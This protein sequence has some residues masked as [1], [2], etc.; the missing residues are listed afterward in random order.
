MAQPLNVKDDTTA[1]HPRAFEPVTRVVTA[2]LSTLGKRPVKHPGTDR[3]PTR[4][5]TAGPGKAAPL[6]A[7]TI[8]SAVALSACAGG[9]VRTPASNSA[10]GNSTFVYATNNNVVTD[11]DPG[12][13]Y[14]NE[15]IA[16][17]NIYESLTFYDPA[18]KKVSPRLATAWTSS[19]DGKTWTF[20]LPGNAKFHS[21]RAL[22]ATAAKESIERTIKL[23]G[24][25][26]YIWASVSTITAA[27]PTSL[28]FNLK[29]PAPLDLIASSDYGAY[30]YDV[31]AAG[32]TDLKSWLGKGHD[33]G[34]GPYTVD[35]WQQGQATELR[36]KAVPDYWASWKG[37]HYQNIEFRVSPQVT[38]SWQLLQRGEVSF[39]NKVN[40]QIFE[41]AQTTSGVHASSTSSFQNDLAMFN[42]A[43]GPMADIRVRKAVQAAIDT[44][45]LLAALKGDGVAASQ[46]I[47]AGL[48]GYTPDLQLR[49]NLETA[50][51]LLSEAG[52]G[53]GGK[54]L[55]LNLT[56]AQGDSD[57]QLF[58]TLLTSA[59]NQLGVKLNA[60]PMQWNAQSAQARST[61]LDS[62]QD[63]LVFRWYPDYADPYTW[64]L[65]LF[66]SSQQPHF[67]VT[68]LDD[69]SVDATIDSI[70]QL[71]ATSRDQAQS[72]YA[73]LQATLVQDKAVVAPLWVTKYERVYASSVGGYVDNPAYP[74]VVFVHDLTPGS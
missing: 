32:T 28:V 41:Q 71:T 14:S 72:A 11:W 64:F 46:L 48:L 19:A 5:A 56:Y 8:V 42:T 21:G 44:D 4:R 50:K 1:R 62:R 65:N 66:H 3:L 52:Y 34:S 7:L 36:L 15:I 55:T 51:S 47:P 58:V 2:V 22:D 16:M 68:Y 70:P 6:L 74:D 29:Y 24:G 18:T 26:A 67:N 57:Q 27:S 12:T 40:P 60:Q 61:N 39:L 33:A 31:N 69:K 10:A 45:G 20:T 35:A 25:P 23:D 9:Q 37:Q 54:Q 59:L 13:S 73:T 38:T 53:P 49:Q 43:S 17:E 30:I 63:I